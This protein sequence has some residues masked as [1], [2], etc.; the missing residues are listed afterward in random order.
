MVSP[1]KEKEKPKAGSRQNKSSRRWIWAALGGV[2]IIALVVVLWLVQN[3][4]NFI[5]VEGETEVTVLLHNE[6]EATYRIMHEGRQPVDLQALKVMLGG[7]VLHVDVKQVTLVHAGQEV[8]LE[9]D[10]S[11][12]AG[13]KITLTPGDT[14]DVRVAMIGQTTGGNYLYGFRISYAEGD[15]VRTTELILEYEY[16]IFVE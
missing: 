5:L 11:L 9:P 3:Q 14:F 10:G 7:Q 1:S 15:R 16:K 4:H 13:T 8:I 6:R 12:P 2:V